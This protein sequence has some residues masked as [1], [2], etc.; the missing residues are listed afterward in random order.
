MT[1]KGLIDQLFDLLEDAGL[2]PTLYGKPVARGEMKAKAL[3]SFTDR[4][5]DRVLPTQPESPAPRGEP[6]P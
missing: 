6:T 1:E 5:A 4:L 3:R 2:R